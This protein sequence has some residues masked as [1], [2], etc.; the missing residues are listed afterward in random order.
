VKRYGGAAVNEMLN[1]IGEVAFSTKPIAVAAPAPPPA[2]VPE[3]GG[4]RRRTQEAAAV[5]PAAARSAPVP[6]KSAPSRTEKP[7]AGQAGN[8]DLSLLDQ[9]ENLDMSQADELFDPD[10]LAASGAAGDQAGNKIS[11]DDALLQGIIGNVD[12]Q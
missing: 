12:D 5:P 7:A 1:M 2:R 4:R 8:F 11:F 10:K 6:A 3:H 9:L